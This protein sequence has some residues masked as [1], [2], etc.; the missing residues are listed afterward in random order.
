MRTRRVIVVALALGGCA[1]PSNPPSSSAT[2]ALTVSTGMTG[3][4]TGA[5]EDSGDENGCSPGHEACECVDG[6]L[7]LA[8]LVCSAGVCVPGTGTSSSNGDGDGDTAD[9]GDETTGGCSGSG[10]PCV[11]D[12]DCDMGFECSVLSGCMPLPG[13]SCLVSSECLANEVCFESSCTLID[14]LYFNVVVHELVPISCDEGAGEKDLY[15]DYYQ[16]GAYVSS[17]STVGCPGYWPLETIV[18]NS[19]Q[20]FRLAFWDDDVSGADFE[21][22][23]CWQDVPGQCVEV[24]DDVMHAG[25]FDGTIGQTHGFYMTIDPCGFLPTDPRCG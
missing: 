14:A 16:G 3:E 17:S 15:Y 19:V 23:T 6:D 9:T 21:I 4:T 25:E 12:M 20:S 10:C 18:Y 8:G 24:P 11:D 22:G 7:C 2:S 1:S 5:E 13:S